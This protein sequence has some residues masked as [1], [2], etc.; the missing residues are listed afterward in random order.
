MDDCDFY[1]LMSSPFPNSF[2]SKHFRVCI[3]AINHL[4]GAGLTELKDNLK[5]YATLVKTISWID[6]T[7]R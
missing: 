1:P 2:P 6:P 4:R 7:F 3:I 5:N